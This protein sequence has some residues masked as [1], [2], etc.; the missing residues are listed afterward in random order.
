MTVRVLRIM[1][2]RYDSL[3][4]ANEDMDRWQVQGSR[5]FGHCTVTSTTMPVEE[6]DEVMT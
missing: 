6:V 1:E 4:R 3:T 2:Y 5:K